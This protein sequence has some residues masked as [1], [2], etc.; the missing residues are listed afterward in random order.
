MTPEKAGTVA[1]KSSHLGVL[2]FVFGIVV[3][4]FAGYYFGIQNSAGLQAGQTSLSG[5]SGSGSQGI[6]VTRDELFSKYASDL[7]LDTTKFESCLKDEKYKEQ[8]NSDY[9]TAVQIGST[10][11][12]TFVVNGQLVPIGAA[13]YESFKDILDLELKNSTDRNKALR[14]VT[15][16]D[17]TLGKKDAPIV[18]LEFSDFQCPFC[19]KFWRETLP[20]IKKDYVETGKVLFVYKDFPLRQIHPHA[21]QAAEAALCANEQGKFW[22]YH[23]T[24]FS[25]QTEWAR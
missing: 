4:G 2:L 23:D 18:M 12:P 1:V 25:K 10:G 17:P 14:F 20:Q 9:T 6:T 11:T 8:V 7:K 22:E 3:G 16:N 15:A 19:G 13:P 24:L 5:E 21:Q